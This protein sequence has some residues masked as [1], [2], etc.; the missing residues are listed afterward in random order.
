MGRHT[1]NWAWKTPILLQAMFAILNVS[2]VLFLPESPRW[3]YANGKKELAVKHMAYLH[4][5]N[6]D[7]NSPMVQLEIQEI[8]EFISVF[9][10]DKRW[11]DFRALF[12]TGAN[13]YRFGLCAMVS[14]WGQLSGNGLITCVYRLSASSESD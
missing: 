13:R 2:F 14:C 6:N 12:N 5:R 8:E 9:G 3:L 7:I 11:W 10:A 1:S 4:T